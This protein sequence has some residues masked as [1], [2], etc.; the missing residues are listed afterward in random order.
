MFDVKG[1]PLS[2]LIPVL[3]QLGNYL[4]IGV[5]H[6]AMLKMA[7]K[8]AGPDILALYI[9]TKMA[10]WNPKVG[11]RNVMDEATKTACARFLAGVVVNVA[12]I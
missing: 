7:G 6:Y 1:L 8:D 4:K 3:T 12:D 10:D 11:A 9:L 2:K 5:D